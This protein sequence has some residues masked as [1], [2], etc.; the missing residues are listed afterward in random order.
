M[1]SP[2]DLCCPTCRAIPGKRCR[3]LTTRT[4]T[5]THKARQDDY[6]D[7][8]VAIPSR[9][10]D[11]EPVAWLTLA[12]VH[13]RTE[14]CDLACVVHNPSAHHMRFWPLIW[15]DDRGIFERVCPEHSIGHPDPDQDF[16]WRWAKEN[17]RPP[18]SADVIDDPYPPSN[19]FD[20]IDVHG[21]CGDCRRDSE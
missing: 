12:N 21:C 11:G 6:R 8:V 10:R 13:P 17:W 20:G 19:P 5:D 9:W 3:T 14:I 15:R 18:I 16:Y 1:S 2:L 4:S 7:G